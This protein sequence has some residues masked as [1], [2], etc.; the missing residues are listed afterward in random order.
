MPGQDEMQ[1]RCVLGTAQQ[2]NAYACGE[3]KLFKME[4]LVVAEDRHDRLKVAPWVRSNIGKHRRET[5]LQTHPR[6][7]QALLAFVGL[8]ADDERLTCAYDHMEKFHRT[9]SMTV[10]DTFCSEHASDE[11]RADLAAIVEERAATLGY[12]ALDCKAEAEATDLSAETEAETEAK[13]DAD[14]EAALLVQLE[15]NLVAAEHAAA[16]PL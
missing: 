9:G 13:T 4:D 14:A 7:A 2:N 16:E 10:R 12:E 15:A 6:S 8:E 5:H 1:I 3:A 11:F